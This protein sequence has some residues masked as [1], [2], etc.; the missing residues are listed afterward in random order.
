MIVD[1]HAQFVGTADD[2]ITSIETFDCFVPFG[3]RS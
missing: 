2:L 1:W 3:I